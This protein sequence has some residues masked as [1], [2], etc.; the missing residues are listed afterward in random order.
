MLLV[1][2]TDEDDM[3]KILQAMS[4][5]SKFLLDYFWL[6][7]FANVDFIK[8]DVLHNNLPEDWREFLM[9]E[10]MTPE[11]L[12]AILEEADH[13]DLRPPD[14]LLKFVRR[15]NLLL[16]STKAA[17]KLETQLK[18]LRKYPTGPSEKGMAAKKAHEVRRMSN[19]VTQVIEHTG[20]QRVVDIG[21][22]LCHLEQALIREVP[23]S[24][25]SILVF[26]KDEN[27][28][29]KAIATLY[30][31]S[32]NS[33]PAVNG[34]VANLDENNLEPVLQVLRDEEA[35]SVIVGLHACGDLSP[36]I[37]KMFSESRDISGL[38]LVQCCFH[39]TARFR[40]RSLFFE[41]SASAA[42]WSPPSLRLASQEPYS[43]WKHL[44]QEDHQRRAQQL[45]LRACLE[46][47]DSK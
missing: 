16:L 14:S 13:S 46:V 38:V 47:G 34:H 12:K 25:K 2:D 32:R 18:T 10:A 8:A 30:E 9:G 21:A 39:K 41:D 3:G 31:P 22:G 29:E 15:R 27:R 36:C 43:R 42:L 1:D 45:G 7:N 11:I 4:E 20:A 19:L 28:L 5:A 23:S 6:F 24:V 37:L 40:P 44:G 17:L 26:E 33:G 35:K